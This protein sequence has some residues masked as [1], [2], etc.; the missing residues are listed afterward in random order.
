M[1]RL[2]D[3]RFHS[4]SRLFANQ[5]LF[6]HSKSS[7][8]YIFRVFWTHQNFSLNVGSISF[9][10]FFRRANASKIWK[11]SQAWP[12]PN[13]A[14][15]PTHPEIWEIYFW[16]F[17]RQVRS[18]GWHA[19]YFWLDRWKTASRSRGSAGSSAPPSSWWVT[20]QWWFH[21]VKTKIIR[22]VLSV[23]TQKV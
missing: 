18:R 1:V 2:P 5:P 20:T 4:K 10:S 12:D 8:Y 11:M 6:D 16:I 19:N 17:L 21:P 23:R 14:Q 15:N 9:S 3:F 22:V 7:L 13:R